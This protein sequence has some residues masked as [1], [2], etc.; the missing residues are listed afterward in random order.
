MGGPPATGVTVHKA[1]DQGTPIPDLNQLI[2]SQSPTWPQSQNEPPPM[3]QPALSPVPANPGGFYTPNAQMPGYTTQPMA[4]QPVVEPVAPVF[5][6]VVPKDAGAKCPQC[7]AH[8]EANARFCG[9]CGLH[10]QVRVLACPSCQLPLEPSA[11]FCGECG[12]HLS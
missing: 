6:P 11:K 9:E 4:P 8:L 10:L 3:V 1:A 7:A 2:A 12:H 5:Q